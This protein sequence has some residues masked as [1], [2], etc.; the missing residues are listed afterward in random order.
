V[1]PARTRTIR[2]ENYL[3]LIQVCKERS[4]A[5]RPIMNAP[6]AKK[7]AAAVAPA[8]VITEQ[9]GLSEQEKKIVE[10]LRLHRKASEM[11]LRKMLGTRRVVG[12]V[13][14]LI[15]KA[16]LRGMDLISKKGVG[17]D[18]EVYEYTGT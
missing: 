7:R 11:D 13:N 5:D 4:I 16:A 15:Q 1:M 3:Q 2:L 9:L 6:Q 18:G 17:V 14:Q 10:F 12:V 8:Q